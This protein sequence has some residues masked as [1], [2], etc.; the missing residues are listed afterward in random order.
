MKK[1][2]LTGGHAGTTALAVI[3]ELVKGGGWDIYWIGPKRAFEGASVETLEA[4]TF[5]KLGVSFHPIVAGRIQRKFSVHTIPSLV[6]IPFGFFHALFLLIKIRPQVVVS[7]GGFAAFPV[8][9]I[10]SLLGKK[11]VIHEQTVAVGLANKLS[12]I[13]ADKIALAREGSK[14]YFPAKKTVVT[15]NPVM[16]S[17]VKVG[18]KKK[19]GTPPTLLIMGGSRGAR[20]I[21]N[22]VAEVLEK[23]LQKYNI[24]HLTGEEGYSEL[25]GLNKKNYQVYDFVEPSIM[26][27]LYKQ[28]DI[29]V[30]R[31]GA[32]TVSEIMVTGRPAIL[33]PIPWTRYDEQTQNAKTAQNAGIATVLPQDR[34]TGESLVAAIDSMV[35]RWEHVV[36]TNDRSLADKDTL[37][38]KC[39]VELL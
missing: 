36:I 20:L 11:T 15:G 29:V 6:R 27:D 31:A 4:K 5:P 35:A 37:A 17:I 2:V 32:N 1:I 39:L 23:L 8:V 10:A 33:I 21:N 28:S 3:E 18:R 9:V 16:A 19:I 7:F 24:I 26:A 34:L 12:S 38:V 14:K 22:A 25:S 30:G 13:F